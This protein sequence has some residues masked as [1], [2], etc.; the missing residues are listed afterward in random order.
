MIPIAR[1]EFRRRKPTE[2]MLRKKREL[3]FNYKP[4]GFIFCFSPDSQSL[5]INFL[6]NSKPALLT[7]VA[8]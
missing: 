1:T 3:V 8:R 7:V 2:G 6:S 5:L 4:I